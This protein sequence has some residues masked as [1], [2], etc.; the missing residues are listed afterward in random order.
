MKCSIGDLSLL[1]VV[2][3]GSG[4]GAGATSFDVLSLRGP[5]STELC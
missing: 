2:V 3:V 1:V 4:A 5:I